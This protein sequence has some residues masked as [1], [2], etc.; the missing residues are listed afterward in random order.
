M[1]IVRLALGQINTT[2]GDIHGNAKKMLDWIERARDLDADILAFPEL[3]TVG[4]PPEDLL[5][6]SD[7]LRANIEARDEIAAAS[8]GMVVIFGFVDCPDDIYNA[9]AIACDGKVVGVYHKQFLPNYSVFD[10]NRYFQAGTSQGVHVLGDVRF[11]V[12]ICED[13]WYPGGPTE[14][15]ALASGA[16]LIINISASPYYASKIGARDRMI[17]TRAADNAAVVALVNLVGGQDEL[18]FDGGSII[19]DETGAAMALGQQFAEDLVVADIPLDPIFRHRLR[20]PRRRK[21]KFAAMLRGVET[22]TTQLHLALRSQRTPIERATATGRLDR[23]SEIYRAL[24]LGVRDYVDKNSFKEVVVAISGGIDSALTAT[25]AVDALGKDRVVGVTMPSR[26]SSDET[27]SDAEVIARNLGIHFLTIP[28]ESLHTT[29]LD[30]LAPVFAGRPH[31]AAEENIQARIRGNLIMALSNKFGWLV[32]TTGN[33]SEMSTGYATLYG[34]MAGGFAVLKDV[35]KVTVFDLARWRNA[36]GP[37]IP[38]STISRP[39]TAELREN[40]KDQDTLPPYETLDPILEAYVE[41]DE[42]V[43]EIARRGYDEKTV[44]KVIRMV[45]INEYK[46]RQAP[47]GIKITPRALGKDRRLPITMRTWHRLPKA[48]APTRGAGDA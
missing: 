41:R 7:L 38:E 34:D 2:V 31:D 29:Y 26:Y 28:I 39:P 3:A 30:T 44:R 6:R 36:Q 48:G 11:G 14:A 19:S 27:R 20:D 4:Y 22:P 13:I 16:Q 33:K 40:Q 15:Q 10:E 17:C 35:Y 18:I 47:P 46:R 9:A 21:E 12:S 42:T 37:V 5:Y 25:I 8:R 23:L 45:D 1:Q 32:L 24:M 43:D